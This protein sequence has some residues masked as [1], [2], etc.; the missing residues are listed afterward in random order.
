MIGVRAAAA[1]PF[2]KLLDEEQI[3]VDLIVGAS[4]G[5]WMAAMYGAGYST[6]E[7]SAFVEEMRHKKFYSQLD[8]HTLLG[9]AH[10]KLAKSAIA[11]GLKKAT[12]QRKLAQRI[13][14]RRRLEDLQ[15]TTVLQV[16]DSI[17]GEPVALTEGNVA[18]AVYAA[19][20]L[21]PYFPAQQ[22]DGRWY[23][24]GSYMRPVP[25]I[26][27]V[28]RHADIII[29]LYHE[30][31][32]KPEPEDLLEANYNILAA[33]FARLIK[34]QTMMAIDLHH[35]EIIMLPLKLN[36]YIGPWE[37]KAVPRILQAAEDLIAA[38]RNEIVETLHQARQ[39][40][41]V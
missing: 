36:P 3:K 20:A 6:I 35:H 27:A 19:S 18:D 10:P 38:R 12:R 11:S 16:C 26:E 9:F 29:A 14:G 30:E 17:A 8:V 13:F 39:T 24:D 23:I 21:S 25:I 34:D 5:A 7:M 28:K 32:P 41:R 1:I 4:S 40:V 37:S 22:I 31:E 2:F 15:P 33:Y